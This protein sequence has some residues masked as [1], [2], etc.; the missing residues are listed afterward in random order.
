MNFQ[1]DDIEVNLEYENDSLRFRT[2]NGDYSL[3]YQ[4]FKETK[5]I[6]SGNFEIV[7]RYYGLKCQGKVPYADLN[8]ISIKI[9]M[10]YFYMYNMWRRVY[11]KE[12]NRDL[13]WLDKDFDNPTTYD[14]IISYLKKKYP[15][16]YQ[17][18]CELLLSMSAEN[19]IKYEKNRNDFY[20]K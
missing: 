18:A 19:F 15:S 10:N 6:V 2:V 11:K 4:T 13:K 20:N 16:D 17:T 12:R 5:E 9:V 3:Q 7:R 8:Q 1:I 14:I